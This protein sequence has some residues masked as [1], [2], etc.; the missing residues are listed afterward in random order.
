M[1]AKWRAVRIFISSTF[2]D[3]HAERDHLVKRVFPALRERLQKYRIHLVDVD[4]RWGITEEE[5]EK[6]QVLDLCLQQIDECRPFFVGILGERYGWVPETFKE[7]VA[8]KYGWVQ[9]HTG[10]S[11]TELEIVHGVLNDPEMH[12]HGMFFFRDPAFIGQIPEA[13][14]EDFLAE[15]AVPSADPSPAE[16]LALLKQAIRDTPLSFEPFDGYPCHYAGFRI[17]WQLVSRDLENQADRKALHEVAE[18]GIVDRKEYANLKGHLRELVHRFGAVHLAGLEEFGHRVSEQ[19][20][21]AIKAKYDL[22]DM[23]PTVMLAETD[24][25]AEEVAYH[26][27][28]MESR[29]RVYVGRQT[30]EDQLMAYAEGDVP[31]PCLVTGRSGTGKSAALARFARRYAYKHQNVLLI[32]HFVGASPGSTSLRR[33][34]RRFTLILQQ[35]FGPADEVPHDINELVNRYRQALDSVPADARVVFVIDAVNQ[36]DKTDNAHSM[37]WLPKELRPQVKVIISCIDDATEGA[38]PRDRVLQSLADWPL[39]RLEIGPLTREERLEIVSRVP[40]LSAKRLDPKQVSLLLS[41]PAT[42]NPL[43][44][45]VALEELRGFG[46]YE[47][48][49]DRIAAFPYE[50]DE[51]VAALFGQVIERLRQ[52]F[53]LDVLRIALAMIACSRGGMS[54]RELLELTEGIGVEQSTGDLF[55]VLRQLRPYLQHRGELLDFFHRGLY[56]AVRQWYFPKADDV[57]PYHQELADYFR[58]KLNPPGR[59]PWTGDYLRALSELP[60]HQTQGGLWN[61]LEATL[62]SLPFLEAKTHAGQVF[63]LAGDF[64]AAV[65]ALPED[66]PQR[67]ILGLLDEAL[68][69]DIHFIAHHAEDYPQGLFQCLWNTCWWYDCPSAKKHYLAPETG[70]NEP[71]PWDQPG[72]KLSDL[73][74]Q[75]RSAKSESV[76]CQPWLRSLRPPSIHL[77]AG[78]RAVF[79]GHDQSV[80][81]TAFSPDGQ[82]LVSGSI[83]MTVRLWDVLTGGEFLLSCGHDDAVTS[84]VFS[85]DGRRIVTGSNDRTL[86]V[87]DAQTGAEIY[88]LHGHKGGITSVAFSPDGRQIASGSRDNTLR[89]WDITTGREIACL[90]GH[91][92]TVA[93]VAFSPDGRR[94]AS[95]SS[96]RSVRVWMAETGRQIKH[97][98]EQRAVTGVAFSPDGRRI[99][100]ATFGVK[101]WDSQ[102][103]VELKYIWQQVPVKSV[104][105]SPNGEWIVAA[106]GEVVL[107]LDAVTGR[108]LRVLHGHDAGV[109]SVAFA[110]D[111][112]RF[113]S[114]SDDRTVRVWDTQLK[115]QERSLPNHDKPVTCVG[116]SG[117]GRRIA[118]GAV[119]RTV[120]VWDGDM[121][122]DGVDTTHQPPNAEQLP[123]VGPEERHRVVLMGDPSGNSFRQFAAL[124]LAV[125]GLR[126]Q[127]H[128]D[129]VT[130]VA[131]S[132]DGQKVVSGS[133]DRTVRL[134][135]ANTGRQLYCLRGHT[136]AVTCSAFSPDGKW[137]VSASGSQTT[138]KSGRNTGRQRNT[139]L[140]LLGHNNPLRLW[141]DG[142]LEHGLGLSLEE[143][144]SSFRIWDARTG[145]QLKYIPQE[146]PVT[147]VAFSPD[148]Q[149][150]IVRSTGRLQVWHIETGDCVAEVQ[151]DYEPGDVPAL[152]EKVARFHLRKVDS[153]A[154]SIVEDSTDKRIVARFPVSLKPLACHPSGIVW[155]GAMS[156]HLYWLKLEDVSRQ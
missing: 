92:D 153:D 44:L 72:P 82:R 23:P 122:E 25:L 109:N 56:K 116:F 11:V 47:Q 16:K 134:W 146:L 9:Y 51:P 36:L 34:L 41:N 10:K 8:S 86:Q 1:S 148:G 128:H 39:E 94:I 69:R 102:S 100:G 50:S 125:I 144:D 12:G 91:G 89:I 60:H 27:D 118:S 87:L 117:D 149:R 137:I 141:L 49:A 155:G 73:M 52:E 45:L 37:Y 96:D 156:D 127:K 113:A 135:D 57:H 131:L 76:R 81:S 67:R 140:A 121:F 115:Q 2:R 5:S 97:I 18:D 22:P 28:F 106:L 130:C 62:E 103:G 111:G 108:W 123:A 29:L 136:E 88:R 63:D 84:V 74:E 79:S 31:H 46:S 61:E 154:E 80:T 14:R 15:L 13:K 4:L 68:R 150:I 43:F 112:R 58:A 35:R 105:F 147:S 70:W 124:I 101:T 98:R 32:P 139:A 66:R 107:V 75:W 6:D 110:P 30:V 133:A 55:F 95:G 114:G 59:E 151:G 143:P 83:D 64:S 138:R 104:V 33:V 129:S 3:M 19:L 78:Q 132:P 120:R 152:G 48:V 53:D 99:A 145:Q 7:E 90:R 65:T 40:S 54:E 77:G 142:F 21:Q 24:P 26:E 17:N 38:G 126:Y 93:S 20:W 42:E 71:P 119:D 85:P